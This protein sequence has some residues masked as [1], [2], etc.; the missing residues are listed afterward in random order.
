MRV[1]GFVSSRFRPPA[2]LVEALINVPNIGERHIILLVDTGASVT[3]LLDSDGGRFGMTIDY[4]RNHLKSAPHKVVGIGGMAETYIIEGAE[5]TLT[6]EEGIEVS[7]TLNLHVVLH[8]PRT[9]SDEERELIL[10]L[11]S[12]LG[13]DVIN[14][15]SLHFSASRG[16]VYLE[17]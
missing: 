9:L 3:T 7:E 8:D 15:Y 6:L 17:R 16:E 1:R 13:R 4:A 2:P 11:P 12:I 5:L 10:R 14:R